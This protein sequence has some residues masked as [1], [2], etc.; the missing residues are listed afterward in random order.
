MLWFL[1]PNFCLRFS[2]GLPFQN[3][4]ILG[5]VFKL[6]RGYQLWRL[7]QHFEN[8]IADVLNTT[9]RG[10]GSRFFWKMEYLT[11]KQAPIDWCSW[12]KD[13]PGSTAQLWIWSSQAQ[14]HLQQ[15]GLSWSCLQNGR[16]SM[17]LAGG[18]WSTL[19]L[20][21]IYKQASTWALWTDLLIQCGFSGKPSSSCTSARWFRQNRRGEICSDKTKVST[22]FSQKNS[23]WTRISEENVSLPFPPLA[24]PPAS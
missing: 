16:G 7:S 12:T 5:H 11:S 19:A 17:C 3:Q 22:S 14:A 10:K 1:C 23:R 15:C 21:G 24:S 9:G 20:K 8:W 4:P 2:C 6:W 13:P 18:V